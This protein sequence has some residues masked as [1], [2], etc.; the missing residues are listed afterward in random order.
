VGS[1]EEKCA[2]VKI[3]EKLSEL[4]DDR[5]LFARLVMVAI[6]TGAPILVVPVVQLHH[7]Y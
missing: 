2:K 3:D 5:N 6:S 4:R 7:Q 1:D